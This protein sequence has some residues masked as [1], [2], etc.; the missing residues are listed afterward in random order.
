MFGSLLEHPLIAVDA[1]REISSLLNMFDKEL[2]GYKLLYYQ[3]M[4]KLHCLGEFHFST[5]VQNS[6]PHFML[7]LSLE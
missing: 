3:H 2:N 4:E 7:L 5:C 1:E 6:T